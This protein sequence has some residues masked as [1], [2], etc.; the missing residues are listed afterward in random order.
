MTNA[1]AQL[2]IF[3]AIG[4]V[5]RYVKPMG[6][7]AGTMQRNLFGL[8]YGVLLPI[9]AL[10]A[11]WKFRMDAKALKMLF[12]MALST[13]GA[14]AAAWFYLK[15]TKLPARIQGA[16]FIAAGF[17][18]VAFLGYP[19]SLVLKN[20]LHW[21]HS[22]IGIEFFLVA[23]VL[24]LMSV[25]VFFLRQYGGMGRAANPA[26]EL[27]KEPILIAAVA[28]VVLGMMDVRVPPL[29][30]L[31]YTKVL[32]SLFPLMLI[33]L[34]L[35]LYWNMDWNKLIAKGLAPIAA[36]KLV[37]VP[38]LA[39]V[40][41]KVLGPVGATT[42]KTIVMLGLMPATLYGFVLCE[43]YKLDNTTY[44]AAVTFMTVISIILIPLVYGL[45]L[46]RL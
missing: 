12:V 28:G 24:I 35:S 27:I 25:G 10:F 20:V 8:I 2:L 9:V 45:K 11:M 26:E 4:V 38:V 43:K 21:T 1:I 15:T 33:T 32:D 17:G 16:L 19:L 42:G 34:G 41:L 39:Y 46:G 36:I 44:T 29:L 37:L 31:A 14:M 5:W 7:N 40:L 30:N 6:I 18:A 13:G 23:N 3:I 22:R